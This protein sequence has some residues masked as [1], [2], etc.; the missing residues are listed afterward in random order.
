MFLLFSVLVYINARQIILLFIHFIYLVIFCS[1]WFTH[2]FIVFHDF[3]KK[4]HSSFTPLFPRVT[5]CI[6]LCFCLFCTPLLR[7]VLCSHHHRVPRIHR[8][9]ARRHPPHTHGGE[10]RGVAG[11]GRGEWLLPRWW[12]MWMNV[13]EW[14]GG[15]GGYG[16]VWWMWMNDV[17]GMR[18]AFSLYNCGFIDMFVGRGMGMDE[19]WKWMQWLLVWRY[20]GLKKWIWVEEES[21]DLLCIAF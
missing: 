21:N 16:D 14:C 18:D 17:E 4:S 12:W 10:G 13:N 11:R 20:S 15:D 19:I 9:R 3:Q 7:A 5:S 1:S 8:R 6:C 2:L